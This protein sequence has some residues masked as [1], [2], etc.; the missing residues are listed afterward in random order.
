M[1]MSQMNQ[2]ICHINMYTLNF[3]LFYCTV[4]SEKIGPNSEAI[5]NRFWAKFDLSCYTQELFL[6]ITN[7]MPMHNYVICGQC[8]IPYNLFNKIN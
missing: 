8:S 6:K 2:N 7:L 4:E 5:C 3:F 1:K